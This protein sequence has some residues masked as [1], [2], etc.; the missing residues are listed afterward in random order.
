[1]TFTSRDGAW[2]V[3]GCRAV[4]LKCVCGFQ[5]RHAYGCPSGKRPW[6]FNTEELEDRTL[7]AWRTLHSKRRGHWCTHTQ[8]QHTFSHTCIGIVTV[9]LNPLRTN[10]LSLSNK[11]NILLRQK[12]NG[13]SNIRTKNKINKNEAEIAQML[14]I[15]FF[16]TLQILI[17]EFICLKFPLLIVWLK[18]IAIFLF[19]QLLLEIDC[20]VRVC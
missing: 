8:I 15:S 18:K 12:S 16:P 19:Y 4:V 20:I 3:L 5:A 17:P 2:A 9:P 11:W 1:M 10:N 7:S 13:Q 6:V 14:L